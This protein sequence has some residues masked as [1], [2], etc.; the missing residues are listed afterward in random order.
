MHET[1]SLHN[2]H[3][4]RW[5]S[6]KYEKYRQSAGVFLVE[7]ARA[8][9]E[10]MLT[11]QSLEAII[12]G[13]ESLRTERARNL[14]Q[15]APPD[16]LWQ[17]N[18]AILRR[19]SARDDPAEVFAVCRQVDVPLGELSLPADPLCVVLDEPRGPGNLG[20]TLRVADGVGVDAVIIIE[21]A[22]DLYHP[23]VVNASVGSLFGL[24]IARAP[25][26]AAFLAW[27]DATW[28]ARP[29]TC[30]IATLPEAEQDYSMLAGLKQP[31]FVLFGNEERGLAPAL[32]RRAQVEIGIQMLG[33][34]DSLNTASA[35][36]VILCDIVRKRGRGRYVTAQH[37]RVPVGFEQPRR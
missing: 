21:P 1:T 12:Y 19:L 5:T 24:C 13:P 28:G 34:A 32:R 11:G 20:I 9:A 2:P 31:I 14:I 3:V 29:E 33:R 26:Q 7:G 8:V 36:A 25:N 17:V 6:L 15:A 27:Y 35:A 18:E 22:V 4:K 23:T 16:L 30:C 37:K 10:A